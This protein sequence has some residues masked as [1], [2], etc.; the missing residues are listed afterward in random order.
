MDEISSQKVFMQYMEY[1]RQF[2]GEEK[3]DQEK[4]QNIE[5]CIK[6]I[7]KRYQPTNVISSFNIE[8]QRVEKMV[9]DGYSFTRF[10]RQENI[11][12]PQKS[13]IEIAFEIKEN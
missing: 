9:E 5:E 10:N 2:S 1:Y 6:E 4:K 3:I 13:P 7:L 11:D 12:K 8:R